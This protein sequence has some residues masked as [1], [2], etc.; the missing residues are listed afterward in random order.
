MPEVNP[1]FDAQAGGKGPMIFKID[2]E[3]AYDHL[4]WDFKRSTLK[5]MGLPR[6]W[7]RQL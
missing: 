7:W 1:Y 5:D 2:L 6:K 3:K 4:E